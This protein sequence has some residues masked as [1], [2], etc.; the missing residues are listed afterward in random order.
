MHA[1]EPHS[2]DI[3]TIYQY[4]NIKSDI[5]WN[6]E[7]SAKFT[8]KPTKLHHSQKYSRQNVPPNPPI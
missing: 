4:F 3:A 6:F 1:P 7:I 5:F 2:N 8:P